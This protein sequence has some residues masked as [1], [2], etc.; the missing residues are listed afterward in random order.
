MIIDKNKL[1][2]GMKLTFTTCNLSL[3]QRQ[4]KRKKKNDAQSEIY[5]ERKK[6]KMGS[7]KQWQQLSMLGTFKLIYRG[8]K[9]KP[10][11]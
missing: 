10:L 2:R 6:P 7:E 1:T 4:S 5:H 3:N 8:E 9:S 11:V